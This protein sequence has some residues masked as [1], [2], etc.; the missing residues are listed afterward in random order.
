MVVEEQV[1]RALAADRVVD[2]TTTGRRS[3]EPRRI[4]IWLWTLEGGGYAISGRPGRPRGWYANLRTT[5]AF[6]VHVKRDAKA[7]LPARALLVNDPEERRRLITEIA[8]RSGSE[9][10]LEERMARSP[11]VRVEFL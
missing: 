4:E 10:E 9:D 6:T 3:G 11:L 5:P 7:D 2:I 8:R 1:A